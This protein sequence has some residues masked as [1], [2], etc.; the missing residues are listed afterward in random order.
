LSSERAAVALAGGMVFLA[1]ATDVYGLSRLHDLFVSFMSGNTTSLGVAIGR[2]DAPRAVTAAVIVALF[3]LG[4]A[5]GAILAEFSGRWQS[6]LVMGAVTVLLT[7]AAA[8]PG[9]TIQIVVLAMG[10]LNA[11]MSRIGV[12]GISLTYVTGALVKFGQGLGRLLC[13][14][15]EA[16][17]SWALQGVLW[18]CLLFGAVAGVCAEAWFGAA[19]VWLLPALALVLTISAVGLVVR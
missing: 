6:V 7:A 9:A 1:G 16:D 12:T 15:G 13:G 2:G 18:L 14:R 3:V 5:V 17:W 10:A 4:V 8:L 19:E 11:A